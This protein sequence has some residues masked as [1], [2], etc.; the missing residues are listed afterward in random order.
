MSVV[1]KWVPIALARRSTSRHAQARGKWG[2][3]RRD[4]VNML[5][6]LTSHKMPPMVPTK[7]PHQAGSWIRGDGA[8]GER[9]IAG[10]HGGQLARKPA[11]S[12][13]RRGG[14]MGGG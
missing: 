9:S 7:R 13:L 8:L 11:L 1:H 6:V 2:V 12:Y 3:A 10:R 4:P 14:Q 5:K